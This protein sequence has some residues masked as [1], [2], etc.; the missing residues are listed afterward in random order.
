MS[1]KENREKRSSSFVDQLNLGLPKELDDRLNEYCLKRMKK[2]GKLKLGLRAAIGRAA[3]AEWL[4]KHENDL[5]I[6]LEI[7]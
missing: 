7:L 5:S 4:D 1:K 6:K 2:N 3:L